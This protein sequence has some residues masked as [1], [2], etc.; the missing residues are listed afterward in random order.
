MPIFYAVVARGKTVLV[1]HTGR[2]GNFPT[3]ARMILA[4]I[5]PH[6]EKRSLSHEKYVVG[7]SGLTDGPGQSYSRVFDGRVGWISPRP[8]AISF[9]ICTVAVKAV[10]ASVGMERYSWNRRRN[11]VILFGCACRNYFHYLVQ[12]GITYMCLADEADK[13]RVPFAFLQD[14]QQR[15]S[16]RYGDRAKTA[17]AFAMNQEFQPE[18]Q[19]RIVRFPA[20]IFRRSLFTLRDYVGRTTTTRLQRATRFGK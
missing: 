11:G 6:D 18:L 7:K 17:I 20:F 1:E 9:L 3:V 15:F 8:V 19:H 5:M 13:Q 12:D 14:I 10:A 16:E 2:S 4:E